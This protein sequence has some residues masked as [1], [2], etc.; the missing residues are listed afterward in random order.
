MKRAIVPINLS[1]KLK[2]KN[3]NCNI[4]LLIM[5]ESIKQTNNERKA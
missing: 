3:L 5:E 4:I 1:H 2:I